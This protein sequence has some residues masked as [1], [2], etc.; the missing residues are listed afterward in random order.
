MLPYIIIYGLLFILSFKIKKDKWNVTDFLFLAILIVFSGI[1]YG[2]GTDY[3]LY[4]SIYEKSVYS[5]DILATNRTG[6]GFSYLCN[7]FNKVGLSYQFLIA[8]VAC[9]TMI[10]FYTFFKK[11][12]T[13]PGRTILL[14]IS[15]GFYTSS[16]NG[17]R[18]MLSVGLLLI[19]FDLFKN[20]RR[21]WSIIFGICSVLIHSSSLFGIALYLIVYLLKNRK[22]N[23]VIVYP[24]AILISMFYKQIFSYV[25]PF[26]E[27]YAGYLDY[28]SQTGIGS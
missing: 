19:A 22:I 2:I 8:F 3:F 21:L 13:N 18:Q 6:I 11:N 4:E 5:L 14:Y 1:R 28:N 23:F 20:K 15:L 16:F 9:I 12:S 26:F 10:C 25:L 24:V 7:I 27:H 17:F